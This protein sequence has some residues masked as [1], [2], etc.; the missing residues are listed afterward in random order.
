MVYETS[1]KDMMVAIR[2]KIKKIIEDDA[3][4]AMYL[5]K[6]YKGTPRSISNYPAVMLDWDGDGAAACVDCDDGTDERRPG[7]PES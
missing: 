5:K 7:P 3:D 6:V 4:L 1:T 2:N